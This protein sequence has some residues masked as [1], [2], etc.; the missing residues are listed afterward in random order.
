MKNTIPIS[1]F[2]ADERTYQMCMTVLESGRL[3]Q[4]PMVQKF[5][6][7][8]AEKSNCEHAVAV[9]NGTTALEAMLR[10]VG[11][12]NK[13]V[14]TTPLTF[15][16]TEQAIRHAG[17]TPIYADVDEK[18]LNLDPTAKAD[19]V[20]PVDLYGQKNKHKGENVY[21][22]AAQSIGLDQSGSKCASIS[23]YTGKNV[24]AGEG[25]AVVTNDSDIAYAIRLWRNQGMAEQYEFVAAS[26]WN[27][28]MTEMSAAI[29]ISQLEKYSMSRMEREYNAALYQ[30]AFKNTSLTLPEWSDEHVW[31]QYT[32][33]HPQRD[34][35]VTRLNEEFIE[36]RVYYPRL[37]S[38]FSS[39]D[40]TPIALKA[41]EEIFSI[42][43]HNHL[44]KEEKDY[45]TKT[46][47][48]VVKEVDGD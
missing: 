35:I 8:V 9:N 17:G 28:R 39:W 19:Y 31:H 7:L 46:V 26:G 16:A 32:L 38:P 43:V 1:K 45:I 3:S 41:S 42:P 34:T 6:K 18:S 47:L 36:A 44:T 20:V 13:T 29:A 12:E 10:A 40:T 2:V 30:Q 14:L 23:F 11:I 48:Q 21:C 37:I 4:G 5:E 22:D 24:G 27:W 25:G 15:R 33:R